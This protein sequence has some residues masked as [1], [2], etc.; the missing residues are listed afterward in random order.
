MLSITL[1]LE[2]GGFNPTDKRLRKPAGPGRHRIRVLCA[3]GS[4]MRIKFTKEN[5]S[6]WRRRRRARSSRGV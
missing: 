6:P 3:M 5:I 1:P 2:P 4:N